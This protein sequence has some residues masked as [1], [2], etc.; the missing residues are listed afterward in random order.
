LL[1]VI[2]AGFYT[3]VVLLITNLFPKQY[4]A[5]NISKLAVAAVVTGIIQGPFCGVILTYSHDWLGLAGWRWLFL[6]QAAPAVILGVVTPFVLVSHAK[7]VKF[8]SNEE[9]E[10]LVD[11]KEKEETEKLRKSGTLEKT[12]RWTVLKMP[13]MWWMSIAAFTNVMAA[14][15]ITFWLP[16]TLQNMGDNLSTMVISLLTVIPFFIGAIAGLVNGW[17]SDKTLERRYH[18]A[19]PLIAVGTGLVISGFSTSLTMTIICLSIAMAGVTAFN[20]TFFTIP[21]AL[22]GEATA[23]V[24]VAIIN[25]IMN[26]GGFVGPT[27]L[28][29]VASAT[30]STAAGL[31]FLGCSAMVGFIIAMVVTRNKKMEQE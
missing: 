25:L 5:R 17:H 3:C 20:G 9:R 22:M 29:S 2:E 27:V 12:S 11:V 18:V 26:I 24:G 1:G 13:V 23:V 28:G 6:L 8:L 30:G 19:V 16:L 31:I 4:Q 10:W 15:G 7:N 21:T 14:Y